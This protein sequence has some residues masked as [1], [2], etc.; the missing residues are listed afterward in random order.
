M[1]PGAN[2]HYLITCLEHNFGRANWRGK[3]EAI[4]REMIC[5]LSWKLL[6]IRSIYI[7]GRDLSGSC[8]QHTCLHLQ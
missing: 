6:Y 5:F 3:G 7:C 8:E 1:G 4:E 2:S